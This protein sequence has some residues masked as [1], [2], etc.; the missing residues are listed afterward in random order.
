MELTNRPV[1]RVDYELEIM[2]GT[3]KNSIA[4]FY[5]MF[6]AE[7][8]DED[9]DGI[10]NMVVNTKF[11][12]LKEQYGDDLLLVEFSVERDDIVLN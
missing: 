10:D 2:D 5:V 1:I 3:G 4:D 6:D 7:L 12:E 8:Y 11:N 9:R